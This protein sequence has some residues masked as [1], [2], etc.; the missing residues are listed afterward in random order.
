M[1]WTVKHR[2]KQRYA[3]AVYALQMAGKLPTI[4]FPP[5]KRVTVSATLVVGNE[6]DHDN[7]VARCKWPLDLLVQLGYLA[8]DRRKNVQWAGFPD[9]IVSRKQEPSL[10]LIITPQ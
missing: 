7:A 6:M 4:P 9:Q 3:A 2:E 10:T 8:D 5:Y 1:H